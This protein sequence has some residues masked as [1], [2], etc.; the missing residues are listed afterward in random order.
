MLSS[1]GWS[2]RFPPGRYGTLEIS[3]RNNYNCDFYCSDYRG[4]EVVLIYSSNINN[5]NVFYTDMNGRRLERRIRDYR[6]WG[7][8]VSGSMIATSARS[9]NLSMRVIERMEHYKN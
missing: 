6:E 7:Q 5:E 4:K 3:V 2:A 1:S 9:K 8:K